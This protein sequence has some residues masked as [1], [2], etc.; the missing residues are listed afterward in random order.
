M[1][2][3]KYNTQV[4]QVF[5]TLE[6]HVARS[7]NDKIQWQGHFRHTCTL[8]EVNNVVNEERFRMSRKSTTRLK[9]VTKGLL[10]PTWALLSSVL[11]VNS[12]LTTVIVV[13]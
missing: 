6:H 11:Y 3:I 13:S 9:G 5:Y 1:C 7:V 4:I 2:T 10:M 8:Q 12:V